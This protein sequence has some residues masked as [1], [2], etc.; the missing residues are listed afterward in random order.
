MP[1]GETRDD[2]PFP[3]GEL[4]ERIMEA[5]KKA[6]AVYITIQSVMG[7]KAMINVEAEYL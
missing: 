6:D 3:A 2:I 1:D 4:G 7:E 5:Q